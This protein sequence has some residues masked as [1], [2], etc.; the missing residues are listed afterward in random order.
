MA[1]AAEGLV[2]SFSFKA[3]SKATDLKKRLW[4]TL[5][6]LIV[7]RIGCYIPVPGIDTSAMAALV[8]KNSKGLLGVFDMM[9]GGSLSRMSIF[10]LSIY[11]YISASIVMQLLTTIV[12]SFEALKKDGES[13]RKKLNQYSRYGTVLLTVVQSYGLAVALE[14]IHGSPVVDPGLLF[15]ISTVITLLGGTLF[16]MWLGE[17]ITSRGLGQGTSMIIFAGIVSKIPTDAVILFEMGRAGSMSLGLLFA[18]FT[19]VPMVIG[20]VVF[21]ERGQRQIPIHY[22]KRQ[23]GNKIVGGNSSHLPLKINSA[24]VTPPIFAMSLMGFPMM[25][26]SFSGPNND[27]ILGKLSGY[28]TGNTYIYSGIYIFLIVFF[29]Y[30]YTSTIFNPEEI[31]ENLK[32]SGAVIMGKRPG[33]QTAIYLDYVLT[34]LTTVGAVYLSFVCV[35]LPKFME[36]SL[37]LPFQFGG[38][39]LFIVVSVTMETVSQ[40]HSYLLAQQYEKLMKR[41]R[42][43]SLKA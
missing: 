43:K 4:F 29:A 1:S 28:L 35:I 30:V 6:V 37:S 24:G 19:M 32:R 31:A 16:L 3:F 8:S 25:I 15:R 12:P 13:G 41:N 38:T 23:V 39:S 5:A 9:G 17:Q 20:F 18:F 2:S 22:P 26:A 7:Y 33:K 36:S 27:G 21:V 34:R 14:K 10:A 11:P 42:L 40:I